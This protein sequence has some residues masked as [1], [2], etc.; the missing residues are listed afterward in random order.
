MSLGRGGFLFRVK[1]LGDFLRSG[2]IFLG[3]TLKKS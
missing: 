3:M 1:S 2:A